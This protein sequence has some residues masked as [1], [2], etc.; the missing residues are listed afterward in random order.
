MHVCVV[1]AWKVAVWDGS[2]CSSA[3]PSL[4]ASL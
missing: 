1:L 4:G 2:V 3:D